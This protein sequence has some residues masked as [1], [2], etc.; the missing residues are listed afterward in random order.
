MLM[1]K[2]NFKS[3]DSYTYFTNPN[4]MMRFCNAYWSIV[5]KRTKY[6]LKK[7]NTYNLSSC[8]QDIIKQ[9][10]YHWLCLAERTNEATSP[11]NMEDSSKGI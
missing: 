9:V 7:H 6:E 1:S 8:N 10:T 2:Y 3:T 4:L 5:L 11:E